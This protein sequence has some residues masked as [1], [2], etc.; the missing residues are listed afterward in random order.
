M[1]FSDPQVAEYVN[2]NFVAAWFN[3]G[4]GFFDN[5]LST[6]RWI[7]SGSLEAY[8]TKNICTFFMTPGGKVFDYVAGSYAPELFLKVL[9]SA[10][11]LRRALFDESLALKEG[12]L[13]AARTLHETRAMT[14]A[15]EREKVQ[16]AHSG[17]GWKRIMSDFRP[18]AYRGQI[19]QH[20]AGCLSSLESGYDYLARL[21][22]RWSRLKELP[23]LDQ[24]RYA[25]L[26]GNTFTEESAQST[27]VAGDDSKKEPDPLASGRPRP[28]SVDDTVPKSAMQLGTRGV[29][30]STGLPD[31]LNLSGGR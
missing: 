20:N 18:A 8:P 28:A 11:E 24:V 30:L 4:P 19:H 3:R 9:K 31:V 13:E 7:F 15:I 27:P 1:T 2:K 12:G 17:D 29:R 21:H 14:W 26:W 10:V 5:D 22:E 6:E 16:K 25:Y 23:D